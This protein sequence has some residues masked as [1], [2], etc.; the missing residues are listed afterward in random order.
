MEC[1]RA[2]L[3]P[4]CCSLAPTQPATPACLRTGPASRPAHL[5]WPC[6]R[7]AFIVSA[8]TMALHPPCIHCQLRALASA[9]GE[10]AGNTAPLASLQACG[11]DPPPSRHTPPRHIPPRH[12]AR[13][14]HAPCATH[15]LLSMMAATARMLSLMARA[16]VSDDPGGASAVKRS[17]RLVTSTR[18]LR[19]WANCTQQGGCVWVGRG[20]H[21]HITRSL[22]L[23][24]N[25]TGGGGGHR[26]VGPEC[27]TRPHV[28]QITKTNKI[29]HDMVD[30]ECRHCC[31]MCDACHQCASVLACRKDTFGASRCSK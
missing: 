2:A 9:A 28:M 25:C 17:A 20:G 4:T 24:A 21:E 16:V 22:S 31:S 1:R 30:V 29:M 13:Q 3:P 8:S 12:A 14:A 11:C 5:P 15:H 18:S 26:A 19:L 7:H 6:T 27:S 23:W 10:G